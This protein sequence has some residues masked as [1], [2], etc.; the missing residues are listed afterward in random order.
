MYSCRNTFG[1][2]S[3]FL[4]STIGIRCQDIP[5]PANGQIHFVPDQTAPFNFGTL[6]TFSCDPGYGLDWEAK[7]QC[8]GN[9]NS[10]DGVWSDSSPTCSR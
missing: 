3:K 4:C 10:T 2:I 6:A 1:L 7:R 9:G 8:G 5:D